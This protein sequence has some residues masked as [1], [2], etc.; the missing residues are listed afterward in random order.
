MAQFSTVTSKGQVTIPAPIRKS[1]N[2]MPFQKVVFIQKDDKKVEIRPA[3]DFFAL[4]GSIKTK[5]KYSDKKA[6]KAVSGF[7]KKQYGKRSK[8]N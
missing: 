2:L 3:P 4:R 7:F 5:K 8:N 6:D 1:L